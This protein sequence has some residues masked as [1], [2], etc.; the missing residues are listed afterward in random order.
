LPV[1]YYETLVSKIPITFLNEAKQLVSCPPPTQSKAVASA[2]SDLPME[3]PV[4]RSFK[5]NGTFM[6]VKG[7]PR[8]FN[9]GSWPEENYKGSIA[10]LL[11]DPQF[12]QEMQTRANARR[13]EDDEYL[14]GI[15]IRLG[16]NG[17]VVWVNVEDDGS[18]LTC[19][20]AE[21]EDQ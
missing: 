12:F 17:E 11:Q 7:M 1:D 14:V 10:R 19:Q 15:M 3:L 9:L 6:N 5:L 8:S 13:R 21:Q 18:E 2:P 4:R 20:T 16:K